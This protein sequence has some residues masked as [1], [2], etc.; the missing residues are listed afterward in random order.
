MNN[1]LQNHKRSD[2]LKWILTL[3]AF[4]LV[5]VMLV[6]IICGWFEKKETR[7]E[8]QSDTSQTGG[9]L[10]GESEGSRIALMSAVVAASDY[11]DYG[12]SPLA[13]NAYTLTATVKP[14]NTAENTG[15]DW[16]MKWK[17]ASSSWA[18]GKS[19]TDYVT[20][21]PSGEEYAESKTVTLANLQPFGEQ[22]VVTATARDNPEVTASCNVDYVQKVTDFSLSFG[23]VSCNFGGTT[24]V[25]LELNNNGSPIGGAATLNQT[26]S[27][28][29][30]LADTFNVTYTVSP[31]ETPFLYK[32]YAGMSD[33]WL[34][35]GYATEQYNRNELET[36]NAKLDRSALVNY[37]VSQKG[38][39][40]GIKY[41]RDNMGLNGYYRY[42]RAGG[43][44][45]FPMGAEEF[46]NNFSPSSIIESYTRIQEG[47]TYN[48]GVFNYS[49]R[50]LDLFKLT[51]R[52][53]GAYS[54]MEKTTTFTM[55]G[56]TNTSPVNA[57]EV[58]NSSVV[59]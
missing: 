39:Y 16:A 4:I 11:E 1:E 56:Y 52:I 38:L 19:V 36:V 15:V 57:M 6:G 23:T 2:T 22:I 14:D 35:F 18:N 45:S 34:D 41:F 50:G 48:D 24:G 55:N 25:T 26:T 5:G 59:F 43:V 46:E 33:Y 47:G 28:V 40:F 37:D 44:Y 20:I 51:V 32:D 27:Q 10:V 53:A 58:S 8:P 12:I 54:S 21:T 29:Y 13:E 49:Y 7:S 9:M 42:Y 31:V 17:D 30:S 3:I